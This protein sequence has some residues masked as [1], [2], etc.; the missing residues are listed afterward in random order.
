RYIARHP[1]LPRPQLYRV[2]LLESMRAGLVNTQRETLD[3]TIE[4]T[5]NGGINLVGQQFPLADDNS[6]FAATAKP[7]TGAGSEA[8]ATA[9]FAYLLA[10]RRALQAGDTD[11]AQRLLS[12]SQSLGPHNYQVY[13]LLAET[14]PR[15]E[16]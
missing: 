9:A 4:A 15:D 2:S 11:Q 13:L 3:A 1:H 6:G 8:E 16:T 7:A 5:L 10:G 12:R 14:V